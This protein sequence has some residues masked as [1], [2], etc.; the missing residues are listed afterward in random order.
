MVI[1]APPAKKRKKVLIIGASGQVGFQLLKN[2]Y[3]QDKYELTGTYHKFDWIRAFI[4]TDQYGI[5]WE[6]NFFNIEIKRNYFDI[7]YIPAYATNVDECEDLESLIINEQIKNIV[8]YNPAAK[9]IFF[10]TDYIFDNG[11]YD[12]FD[13]PNPINRYGFFKLQMEHYILANCENPLIIRTAGVYGF[14]MQHKNF[15]YRILSSPKSDKEILIP[16]DQFNCPTYS[17]NL[18]EKTIKLVEEDAS[19]I[20]HIS[21]PDYLNRYEFTKKICKI[22]NISDEKICAV[23]TNMLNQKALRP[24]VN[25]ITTKLKRSAHT[26]VNDGLELFK[27]EYWTKANQL[28]LPKL[29]K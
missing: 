16:V 20:Y 25:L 22:F 3:L 26:S 28:F 23:K 21:G 7:I 12:E 27:E 14:D 18:V 29:K 17:P 15:V 5:N 8:S 13:M 11:V 10:S 24:S 19:G 1:C 6:N 4:P 2:L 9:I